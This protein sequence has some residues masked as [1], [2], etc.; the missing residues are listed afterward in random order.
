M[1]LALITF[2]DTRRLDPLAMFTLTVP[3]V[4]ELAMFAEIVEVVPPVTVMGALVKKEPVLV[5]PKV[6]P[7]RTTA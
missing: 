5:E 3:L 7:L 2:P 4:A 6:P 1:P